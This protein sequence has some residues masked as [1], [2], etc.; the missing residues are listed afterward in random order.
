M[1]PGHWFYYSKKNQIM[2]TKVKISIR[3]TFIQVIY[4]KLKTCIIL[5]G[6]TDAI[7]FSDTVLH[8]LLSKKPFLP[9]ITLE[10]FNNQL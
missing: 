6:K 7:L 2:H 3:Q 8:K 1:K 4:G 5:T 10:Y 9:Q